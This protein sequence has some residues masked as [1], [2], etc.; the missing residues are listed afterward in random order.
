MVALHWN[1]VYG[2]VQSRRLGRSLG[3]NLLPADRKTCSFNCAYCQYGWSRL[4]T[5]GRLPPPSQWPTRAQVAR[6]VEHELKQLRT[7]GERVDRLTLAG[8]GEPTLHPDF[9]AIVR[10]LRHI[11]DRLAPDLPVAILSNSGTLDRT[12][13]R[14]ALVEL[15]ERHMKLDAGDDAMRRR[16]NGTA[17][18]PGRIVAGLKGLPDIFIQSMFVGDRQGRLDNTGH[19][20]VSRWLAWLSEI[21]PRGVHIYTI[22]RQPAFP[23]LRAVPQDRLDAIAQRLRQTGIPALTFS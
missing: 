11:R 15:D 13:V 6:A 10:D 21:R 9:P 16:L 7:R 22:D 8:H 18:E 5:D 3:V 14:K 19:E 4:E 1:V 20:T 23:F 17:V 12:P 2:P